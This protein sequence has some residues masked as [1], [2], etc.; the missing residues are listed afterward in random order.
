MSANSGTIPIPL[1]PIPSIPITTNKL[2][3]TVIYGTLSNVDKTDGSIQASASFQ[4]NV[5]IYGN[6]T[7]GKETI[8]ASNNANNTGG[9][10]Q[11][12]LNKVLYSIPLRTLSYL[13]NV[14]SDIQTQINSISASSGNIKS[15]VLY[16][17][18][19]NFNTFFWI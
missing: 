15:I 7:L 2:R 10:I 11:F 3:S 19:G 12:S 14:T 18:S 8:D 6:L 16:K 5:T 17:N 4:R 13:M 9:N 1:I